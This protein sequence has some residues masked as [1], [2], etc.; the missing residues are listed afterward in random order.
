[1]IQN[2]MIEF[3]NILNSTEWMDN[4]SKKAAL[5]KLDNI[6]SKIG[7]SDDILNNTYLD[8]YYKGV[9]Q[10]YFLID[11]FSLIIIKIF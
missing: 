7:Y 1:M 5:D 11:F 10:I 3:R 9:Y 2:I 6:D 4:E 8:K